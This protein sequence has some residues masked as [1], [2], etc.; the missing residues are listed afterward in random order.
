MQPFL[1]LFE[2]PAF[3]VAYPSRRIRAVNRRVEEVFHY[4][5]HELIGRRT[6]ILHIDEARYRAF[7]S[8]NRAR[9]DAGRPFVAHGWMRRRDGAILPTEHKVSPVRR[10]GAARVLLSLVAVVEDAPWAGLHAQIDGLTE[11]ER[12]I[13]AATLKAMSAKEVARALAISPRTVE[14]HRANLLRKMDAD[15]T[16]ALVAR[17]ASLTPMV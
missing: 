16:A 15:S 17:F 13:L 4:R 9:L 2:E 1:D 7:R 14:T 12:E 5:A 3:A 6:R 8:A 11:R 10:G